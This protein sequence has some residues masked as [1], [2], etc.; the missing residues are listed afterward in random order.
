MRILKPLRDRRVALLFSGQILSCVGDEVYGVAIVWFAVSLIGEKAG[1]LAALQAGA[2][3]TFSFFGGIWADRWDQQKTLIWTD[4][5]RGIAVLV[6]V[7]LSHFMPISLGM[8]IPVVIIESSL[9]GLFSPAMSALVPELVEERSLLNATNALMVA[10]TRLGRVIG[11]GFVA[12]FGTW[13]PLIH[14][15][16]LDAITFFTSAFSIR[17]IGPIKQSIPE[18]SKHPW[19]QIKE[20]IFS[21]VGHI[22]S[23]PKIK[24]AALTGI[25]S[26]PTWHLVM[27]LSMGLLIHERMPENYG[28]FG[29]FISAYGVGNVIGNIWAGS[30]EIKRPELVLFLGRFIAGIGFILMA[31]APNLPLLLLTAGIAAS[32]GPSADLGF[33][34]LVQN[35]Y[36]GIQAA[37]VFRFHMA[38]TQ[39]MILIAFALSPILFKTVGVAAVIGW[40]GVSIAL[41]GALGFFAKR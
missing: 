3:F 39:F 17:K 9:T 24:F 29:L 20:G 31:F 25:L 28:A 15:F 6:P 13:L 10:T 19:Q 37:R 34:M 4:T 23:D 11:P 26:T 33:I 18:R 36:R 8:L 30:V 1:Y 32:G 2:V 38:Y 7:V 12:L 22:L 16:T 14:L 21:G 35:R 5:I 40:C 41:S 27:P